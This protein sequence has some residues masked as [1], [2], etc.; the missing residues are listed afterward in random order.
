MGRLAALF[1]VVLFATSM[2]VY[3]VPAVA[4]DTTVTFDLTGG[5][6]SVSVPTSAA[7]GSAPTGGGV[8]SGS[9]GSVTVTDSRG[10][11]VAIW[12]ATVSASDFVTGGGGAN[13]K[14]AKAR[15][16]YASGLATATSGIGAFVP[17]TAL[18]LATPSTAAA[19]AG[20][21]GNN[22]AT[23]NPTVSVTL[24]G[25]EVAGAYSGTITHSVA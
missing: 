20:G 22:S 21:V 11:L 25:S 3:A 10:S 15:I 19:W 8:I 9:L 13:E 4:Q 12:T 23:W 7:L 5:A 14:V 1:G 16:A 24:L 17:G 6:L 2:V 18:T